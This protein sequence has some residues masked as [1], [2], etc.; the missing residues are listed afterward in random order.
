MVNICVTFIEI[1]PLSTETSRHVRRSRCEQT[2]S[3]LSLHAVASL[4]QMC[5]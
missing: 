1:P 4:K 5:V 2:K 3:K